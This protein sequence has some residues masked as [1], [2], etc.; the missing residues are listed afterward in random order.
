MNQQEESAVLNACK[1]PQRLMIGCTGTGSPRP[2]VPFLRL[3]GRWLDRAGFAIGRR[4]K[5][6]VS[7]G[8]LLIEM[9][10]Q[11]RRRMHVDS[12]SSYLLGSGEAA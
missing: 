6:E 8:R 11:S 4:V 3:S 10:T 7:E 9:T 1:K 2:D 12:A 5:V